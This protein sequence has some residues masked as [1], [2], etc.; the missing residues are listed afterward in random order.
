MQ[1]TRPKNMAQRRVIYFIIRGMLF[2]LAIFGL[3]RMISVISEN[4]YLVKE[5]TIHHALL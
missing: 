4:S 2:C 3:W 1:D 5:V